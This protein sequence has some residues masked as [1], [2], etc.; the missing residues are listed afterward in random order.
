[1]CQ[2]QSYFDQGLKL[3]HCFWD[4]DAYRAFKEAARLDPSAAMA[5][6]GEFEA[7]GFGRSG[8][9]KDEKKAA[10]DEAKS[11][12]AKT[13]E[14]EQ[15]YIRAAEHEDKAD[16]PKEGTAYQREMEA[17]IDRYPDDL[18]AQTFLA[19]GVMGGYETDGH[20][21]EGELYA[22]AILRTVLAGHPDNA[23]ANHYRIHDRIHAMEASSRPEAA[24]KSADATPTISLI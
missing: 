8:S 12:A 21:R 15:F 16:D 1:M 7:L 9:M 22:Q 24:L 17:L 6:W 18:N 2:A 10:L 19:L 3:L 20:P 5:Y 23:A 11:L 13:S 14:H 4:F